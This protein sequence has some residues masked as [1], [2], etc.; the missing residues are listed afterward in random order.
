MYNIFGASITF[1]LNFILILVVILFFA[2][3]YAKKL[4]SLDK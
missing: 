3:E 2:V 1:L 4:K